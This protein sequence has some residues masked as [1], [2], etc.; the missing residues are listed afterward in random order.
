MRSM[1]TNTF[2]VL[3]I[4]H[5]IFCYQ[6]ANLDQLVS[7]SFTEHRGLRTPES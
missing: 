1:Y 5:R 6:R 7:F 4:F 3:T 2:T